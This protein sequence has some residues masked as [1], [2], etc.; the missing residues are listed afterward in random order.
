MARCLHDLNRPIEASRVI[1]D[2]RDKFSNY[3]SN[4]S[5]RAL[6]KDIMETMNAGN[7]S[8]SLGIFFIM[9]NY[10]YNLFFTGGD[11]TNSYHIPISAYEYEWR[12]NTTDYKLRFCGH[13]N[14]T[15]DIKEA[16]YFG[17][18]VKMKLN[19]NL[20]NNLCYSLNFFIQ[21]A[22]GILWLALMTV[23]F[24]FG[25]GLQRILY[26][27]FVVMSELLIASNHIHQHVYWQRVE[28][29][30]L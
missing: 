8:I 24:L 12:H 7:V 10:P 18:C 14:T 11:D 22:I 9:I 4:S 5:Y 1:D 27:F 2:F 3:S 20:N 16:N 15:T 28:S 30:L 17:K 13:C 21:I 19:L 23:L 26:A 6:R 29:I 25:T